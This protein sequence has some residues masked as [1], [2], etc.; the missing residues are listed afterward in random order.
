VPSRSTDGGDPSEAGSEL[1]ELGEGLDFGSDASGNGKSSDLAAAGLANTSERAARASARDAGTGAGL[2]QVNEETSELNERLTDGDDFARR[3]FRTGGAL[4]ARRRRTQKER[5]MEGADVRSRAIRSV[6]AARRRGEAP[7]PVRLFR[8]TPTMKDADLAFARYAALRAAN[9]G[10]ALLP[11]FARPAP[12]RLRARALLG[13]AAVG[14]GDAETEAEAANVM[15]AAAAGEYQFVLGFEGVRRQQR[16]RAARVEAV[17]E[18]AR[19]RRRRAC[20]NPAA[21]KRRRKHRAAMEVAIEAP[22]RVARGGEAVSAAVGA[23]VGG[24]SASA[25][26][27]GG[28]RDSSEEDPDPEGPSSEATHSEWESDDD[29]PLAALAERE[30][31]PDVTLA[32]IAAQTAREPAATRRATAKTERARRDAKTRDDSSSGTRTA[33]DAPR[34]PRID[35]EHPSVLSKVA[36]AASCVFSRFIS[37]AKP[38]AAEAK[39]FPVRS[40]P[41]PRRL[42][43]PRARRIKAEA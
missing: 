27:V 23:A 12:P 4:P 9:G 10:T 33:A 1:G 16:E 24:D 43:T 18:A 35:P 8:V 30:E 28:G 36:S 11:R 25:E 39:T 6:D 7:Y 21:S 40:P 34:P 41:T 22:L 3:G 26:A 17:K 32:E 13:G 20:F 37:H 2:L 14:A 31:S 5:R 15:A 42:R 38:S 29:V 19:K